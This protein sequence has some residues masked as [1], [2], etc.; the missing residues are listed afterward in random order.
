MAVAVMAAASLMLADAASARWEERVERQCTNQQVCR[1]VHKTQQDCR[2]EQ[3]CGPQAQPTTK[4]QVQNQCQ[5]VTQMVPVCQMVQQCIQGRCMPQQQCRNVPQQ[6]QVCQ[7]R[8]VCQQVMASAQKCVPQQR[9]QPKVVTTQECTSQPQC[10]NVVKRVWVPDPVQPP[11]AGTRP[12]QPPVVQPPIVQPH[13]AQPPALRPQPIQPPAVTAVRPPPVG[14][15][16]PAHD[17]QTYKKQLEERLKALQMQKGMQK[18]VQDRQRLDGIGRQPAAQHKADRRHASPLVRQRGH[19]RQEALRA[20]IAAKRA[21][22]ARLKARQRSGF[23]PGIGKAATS[24]AQEAEP[25]ER[26]DSADKLAELQ[27][28]LEQL[29]A[30]LG[31]QERQD[32]SEDA[33]PQTDESESEEEPDEPEPPSRQEEARIVGQPGAN[34]AV[35]GPG[36]QWQS[37]PRARE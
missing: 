33:E 34:P 14:V 1:P 4:C 15:Q 24:G 37:V 12:I 20:E 17:R 21:Q 11:M 3:V 16:P 36:G 29:T 6:Q 35:A 31:Q 23:G 5:L 30:A 27:S 32:E 10:Q 8:Q 22:I 9:C 26:E 7:P 2:V 18:Q 13:P 28:M 19:E 25:Q